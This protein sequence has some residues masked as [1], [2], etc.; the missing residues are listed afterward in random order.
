LVEL[1][2]HSAARKGKGYM[3]L[4]ILFLQIYYDDVV[5]ASRTWIESVDIS[6]SLLSFN[7]LEAVGGW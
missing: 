1:D 2:F 6:S 3:I 7:Y 5:L 4:V